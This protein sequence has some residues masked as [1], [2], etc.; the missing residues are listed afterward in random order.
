MT[1]QEAINE[2]MLKLGDH[3]T[4]ETQV[5]ALDKL[6]NLAFAHGVVRGAEVY[7]TTMDMLAGKA[8]PA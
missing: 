3:P 7:T 6:Y 2:T 1:K 5:V 4:F 8:V